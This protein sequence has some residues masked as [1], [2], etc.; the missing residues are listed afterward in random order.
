[1]VY[2]L[3]G[4][5]SL[6]AAFGSGEAPRGSTG[7]LEALLAQPLGKMLLLFIAVGLIGFG[8]WRLVQAFLDPDRNGT[9]WS[10]VGTR[11][12]YA[13][14][15]VM[16]FGLAA[17][18]LSIAFGSGS[19]SDDRTAQDWT[20]WLMSQPFGRWLTGAVAI[21]VVLG[22]LAFIIEAWRGDQMA[23]HVHAGRT[24]DAWIGMVGRIGYAGSGIVF[25]LVG[26]LLLIAAWHS[27]AA[28]AR[29]LGGALATLEGQPYGFAL[30]AVVAVG[31][32]AFGAFGILQGIYRH[33]DPPT[34]RDAET[35][36]SHVLRH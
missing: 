18:A 3:V 1:M 10:A 30:L 31:L 29:G 35:A 11:C 9:S 23:K 5:L 15:S 24:G 7:A 21:G 17:T 13:I 6:L 12:G 25:V 26:A 32:F 36:V 2:C 19:S 22:G 14:G 8:I 33:I 16:Y 28:E 20:A 4:G 34:V 27:N